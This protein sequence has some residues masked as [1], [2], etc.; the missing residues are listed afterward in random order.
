MDELDLNAN[1]L[2]QIYD[3]AINGVICLL[4]AARDTA[5]NHAVVLREHLSET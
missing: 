5:C 3:G 2:K 1:A 4:Y